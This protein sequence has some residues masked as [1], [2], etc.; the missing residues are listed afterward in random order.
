MIAARSFPGMSLQPFVAGCLVFRVPHKVNLAVFIYMFGQVG[1]A[2][3]IRLNKTAL[4]PL[5]CHILLVL[6]YS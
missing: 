6:S 5:A 4:H 3:P 1:P 2:R